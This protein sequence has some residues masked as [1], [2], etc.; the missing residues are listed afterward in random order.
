MEV[1]CGRERESPR[2][3]CSDP[4]RGIFVKRSVMRASLGRWVTL[5]SR[6]VSSTIKLVSVSKFECGVV[7]RHLRCYNCFTPT[8]VF[9]PIWLLWDAQSHTAI[10]TWTPSVHIFSPT[11]IY[12][13]SLWLTELNISTTTYSQ[14]SAVGT[15]AILREKRNPKNNT[16]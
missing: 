13:D 4:S 11:S 2:E 6:N 15:E 5:H 14:V 3:Q 9:K 12:M 16:V 7:S 8:I 10:S 1:R